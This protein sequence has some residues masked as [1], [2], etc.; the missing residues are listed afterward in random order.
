MKSKF[1]VLHFHGKLSI[2]FGSVVKLIRFTPKQ[3]CWPV[4]LLNTRGKK[5]SD[6]SFR[7]SYMDAGI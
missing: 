6:I 1:E 4:D 3:G 7:N 2:T 5:L